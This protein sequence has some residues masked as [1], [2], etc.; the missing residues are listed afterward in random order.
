MEIEVGDWVTT[1]DGS[2]GRVTLI[3][4]TTAYVETLSSGQVRLITA[5]VNTLA[6]VEPPG[7]SGQNGCSS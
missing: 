4:G 6:R 2:D 7:L 5:V 3:N 1:Y